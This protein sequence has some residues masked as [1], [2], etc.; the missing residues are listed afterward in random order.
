MQREMFS[1]SKQAGMVVQDAD[2]CCQNVL[3]RYIGVRYIQSR[4]GSVR[5]S[6][7]QNISGK[8]CKVTCLAQT[9]PVVNYGNSRYTTPIYLDPF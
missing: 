4:L 2:N 7:R 9:S 3:R 8:H 1:L 5:F 6:S